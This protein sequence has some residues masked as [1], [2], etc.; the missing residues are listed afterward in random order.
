VVCRRRCRFW[1]E[2]CTESGAVQHYTADLVVLATAGREGVFDAMRGSTSERIVRAVACP[3]LS[4][5]Q[6]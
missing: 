3:V 2:V 1:H 4:V 6:N 5:P